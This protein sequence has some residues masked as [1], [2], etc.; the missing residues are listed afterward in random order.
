MVALTQQQW[1]QGLLTVGID[2][3]LVTSERTPELFL[4]IASGLGDNI[5]IATIQQDYL[6]PIFGALAKRFALSD[7][8]SDDASQLLYSKLWVAT[9]QRAPTILAYQGMGALGVWLHVV[10][11]RELIS[12]YRAQQRVPL[13]F[14]DDSVM[15]TIGGNTPSAGALAN[16]DAQAHVKTAYVAAIAAL[17]ARQRLILR[18][19]ICQRLPLEAIAATYRVNRVTVARWLDRARQDI[20]RRMRIELTTSLRVSQADMESLL[21]AAYSLFELSTDRLL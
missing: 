20:A 5:A 6:R 13:D 21:R 15:A 16:L 11:T 2:P 7:A 4:T 14:Y 19:H 1:H 3:G 8:A 12:R 9:P 17:D 10:A 18:M